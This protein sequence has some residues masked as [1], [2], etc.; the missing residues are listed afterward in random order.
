MGVSR[1]GS[2]EMFFVAIDVARSGVKCLLN[3]I[4]AEGSSNSPV[5]KIP[6]RPFRSIFWHAWQ[7]R[8]QSVMRTTQHR[9]REQMQAQHSPER[10][11]CGQYINGWHTFEAPV[12]RKRLCSGSPYISLMRNEAAPHL[13]RAD[14]PT[15]H[16]TDRALISTRGH[17]QRIRHSAYLFRIQQ[18]YEFQNKRRI[19]TDSKLSDT[20]LEKRSGSV[21]GL[22][23]RQ[24]WR[25][26]V[27]VMVAG[28]H[29]STHC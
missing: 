1:S 29:T 24:D 13:H 12:G 11:P 21:D 14:V 16:V 15:A 28:S 25:W 22:V 18:G 27:E 7:V 9:H 23:L 17:P 8:P 19:C 5:E 26:N 6:E 4:L 10:K 2:S 3:P 20:A